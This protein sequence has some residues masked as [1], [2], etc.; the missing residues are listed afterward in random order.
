MLGY[1][2]LLERSLRKKGRRAFATILSAQRTHLLNTVG[3]PSVVSNT[4]RM[5]KLV[6]RVEPE[7]ET[8]FEVKVEAWFG[9][10]EDPRGIERWPVLYD[11]NDHNKVIIDDSNEGMQAVVDAKVKER[12]DSTV[13]TMR[14]RGQNELARRYQEV[15]DDGLTTKW[16]NDPIELREQI[17]ERREKIKEIM[18][19]QTEEDQLNMIRDNAASFGA[20]AAAQEQQVMKALGP[21]LIVNGQPLA[22]VAGSGATSVPDALTKLANLR[23][24]GVLT[25]EEFETQ[26]M[27][28]LGE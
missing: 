10:E 2:P 12:T 5:W 4:T 1:H 21:S 11:P 14:S 26:K 19:G 24:R 22:P 25:D 18:A 27:K 13:A 6:L 3:D 15:F 23:D 28:L 16:S 7:R 20:N 8:P 9:Q 17:R